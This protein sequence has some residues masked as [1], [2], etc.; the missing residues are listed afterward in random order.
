[1]VERSNYHHGPR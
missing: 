1:M